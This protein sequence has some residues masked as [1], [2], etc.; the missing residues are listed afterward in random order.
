MTRTIFWNV[1]TQ[2]DFMRPDGKLAIAGAQNIEENLEHITKLAAERN[3]KV[4]NTADWHT[5]Q[6]REIVTGEFPE[7]CIQGTSGAEYVPATQPDDPYTISWT[8]KRFD[9]HKVI[10]HR[11]IILYKDEF[12]VFHAT[13][14]PHTED[15]LDILHPN[16]VFV[17]GVATNV[18][19]NDAVL[20]LLN[21]SKKRGRSIDVYVIKDAIK[22]LPADIAGDVGPVL[23]R[24]SAEGAQYTT[25][26]SLDKILR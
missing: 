21:Y 7:H 1:D 14:A 20:G 2:Y 3:I 23:D 16:E 12:D 9:A 5:T 26:A 8:D 6:S 22:E 19:V 24:W 18:C 15:V 4:V 25:T 13:G 10:Q 11:N 17:Y